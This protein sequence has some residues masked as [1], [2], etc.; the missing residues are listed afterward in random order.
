MSGWGS[1]LF[2][3]SRRRH[4]R[5]WRDWSSDVC[6]SDPCGGNGTA[7]IPQAHKADSQEQLDS[8]GD[9]LMFRA[10]YRRFHD[11]ESLVLNHSVD[12]GGDTSRTA[13]RWY[14]LRDLDKDVP[15][16]FQQGTFTPDTSHRWMGSIAMDGN[17]NMAL[18]YNVSGET[19][20]PGIR[21][22]ARL[23]N[24]PKGAIGNESSVKERSEEHK[25]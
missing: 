19:V 14:E 9:R 21:I 10:A 11:H 25:S 1:L 2:L 6:S 4:T 20:S 3:S 5:Y 7:G 13:V 15:V 18:G 22:A 24:D 23:S 17:G 16:V 8:L 12:T